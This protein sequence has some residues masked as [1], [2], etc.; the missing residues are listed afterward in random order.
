MPTVNV[1]GV[2]VGIAASQRDRHRHVLVRH[3]RLRVTPSARRFD[4]TTSLTVIDTVAGA[5][6]SSP[7]LTV[8]V[9]CRTRSSPPPACRSGWRPTPTASRGPD[10]DAD[11]ERQRRRPRDPLPA[12]VTGHRH[13]LV[14]RHR[15]RVDAVGGWLTV[16]GRQVRWRCR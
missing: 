7:S 10:R 16:G 13:V 3:H 2:A 12:N 9:N 8:N 11:G 15:L 1:N 14:R 5:D 6:V 4:G